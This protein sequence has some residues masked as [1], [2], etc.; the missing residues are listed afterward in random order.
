M[1]IPTYR[2]PDEAARASQSK[3]AVSP[4]QRRSTPVGL[5]P[6]VIIK[7]LGRDGWFAY[8]SSHGIRIPDT[9]LRATASEIDS[10]REWKAY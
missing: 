5:R 3:M 8:A 4:A 6:V 10:V 7:P 2:S 1:P 9:Y